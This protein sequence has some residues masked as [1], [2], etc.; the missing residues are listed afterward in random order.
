MAKNLANTTS[1][2]SY[3]DARSTSWTVNSVNNTGNISCS[4]KSF[5]GTDP[6]PG[7]EKQCFC[8]EHKLQANE[9]TVQWV[10]SMWRNKKLEKQARTA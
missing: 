9:E 7:E 3:F 1:T 2:L 5:E 4:A 6:L 8:D 10:K